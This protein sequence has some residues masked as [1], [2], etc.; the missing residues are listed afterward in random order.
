[1]GRTGFE[2]ID[3]AVER[4]HEFIRLNYIT[5]KEMAKRVGVLSASMNASLQGKTTPAEPD[6]I[7]SSDAR[8]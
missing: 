8:R 2:V 6:R 5:E 1:L 4:L 7:T 3:V